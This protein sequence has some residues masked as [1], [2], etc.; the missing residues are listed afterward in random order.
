MLT[1]FGS[2][3][4]RWSAALAFIDRKR[5]HLNPSKG[6]AGG[7]GGG[8]GGGCPLPPPIGRPP[9][10]FPLFSIRPFRQSAARVDAESKGEEEEEKEEGEEEEE[11]GKEEARGRR[12]R[13]RRRED[14]GELF[15]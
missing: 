11:E 9:L 4:D 1:P 15:Y 8:G 3:I 12:R 6:F 13:R 10:R 5:S 7:G 14:D 2:R